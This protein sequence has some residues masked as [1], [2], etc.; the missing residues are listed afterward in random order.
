[1]FTISRKL[2]LLLRPV[3]CFIIPLLLISCGDDGD[4]NG[5]VKP[6][7]GSG[8]FIVNEG[9]FGNSNT[10]LSFY[11]IES[12]QI[13]NNIF[14]STNGRP[15][16]DQSQS[17]TIH[18]HE[19]FIVVQNSAKIEVIDVDNFESIA[20]ISDHIISPRYF[21]GLDADKGYVSDWG[22]GFSGSVHVID[23]TTYSVTKTIS[24]GNG[25]NEMLFRGNLLYVANAGGFGVANTISVID[26][27]T[28]EVIKTIE[29]G[30]NPGNLE[31]DG[32]GNIWI[33]GQGCLKFDADFSI[34]ETESSH[35][36]LSQLD[37]D[38]NISLTIV[39][40]GFTFNTAANLVINNTTDRIFFTY[41]GAVRNLRST[42]GQS[43]FEPFIEQSLYGLALD[44]TTGN[45]IGME[46]PDFSSGGNMMF[47]DE[48]GVIT[49]SVTA[50]IG[51]NSAIYKN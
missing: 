6:S 22:D 5:L 26:T 24:T 18:G 46:A 10:S 20:T 29:V 19:G 37:A 49:K 17:M 15:L 35:S 31:L 34:V 33:L 41:D 43:S 32:Q 30:D 3:F 51:P 13:T 42:D 16:G 50:G 8:F 39:F 14:Q 12:G 36:W 1:M 38:D 48:T 23:L 7:A 21:V 11:S 40:D 28:D 2:P 44:P 47:Y 9:G 25:S 45:L 4:D 27:D